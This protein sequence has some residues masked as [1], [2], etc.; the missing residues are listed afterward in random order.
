MWREGRRQCVEPKQASFDKQRRKPMLGGLA[1]G[2][3]EIT[4]LELKQVGGRPQSRV[5][6]R[7]G[8]G[9]GHDVICIPCNR[10]GGGGCRELGPCGDHAGGEWDRPWE[11]VWTVAR[12]K[13]T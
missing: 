7:A 3:R 1:W 6:G 2:G 8:L 10:N 5:G 9:Q 4:P 13:S 11:L 12:V